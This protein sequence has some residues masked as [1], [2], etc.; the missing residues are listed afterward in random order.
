MS[1]PEGFNWGSATASYQVE[2]A[3]DVGGRSASIW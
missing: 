1:F 3:F 2:G